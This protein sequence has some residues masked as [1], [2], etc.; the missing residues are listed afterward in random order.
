[1]SLG[2]VICSVFGISREGELISSAA[3]L[4]NFALAITF[5]LSLMFI[6]NLCIFA[7]AATALGG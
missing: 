2:G 1:L 3:E 6:I 5:S 7:G 4:I